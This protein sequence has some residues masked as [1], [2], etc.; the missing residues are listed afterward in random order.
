[1]KKI[2][3]QEFKVIMIKSFLNFKNLTIGDINI[4]DIK[5]EADNIYIKIS[6]EE[7]KPKNKNIK[8]KYFGIL[9][10]ANVELEKSDS[11]LKIIKIQDIQNEFSKEEFFVD[12][13]YI[14]LNNLEAKN[15]IY[16]FINKVSLNYFIIK[17]NKI[18]INEVF[19]E[20]KMSLNI[21]DIGNIVVVNQLLRIDEKYIEIKS[22]F[23]CSTE[24]QNKIFET[25][26]FSKQN[27]N[28]H[29]INFDF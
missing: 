22:S 25:F 19:S 18:N 13:L 9:Y 7:G 8:F 24:I 4:N 29:D 21:R 26:Y 17:F 16:G 1:M 27:T 14:S 10:S 23:E 6:I 28:I 3:E 20:E 12:N 15:P 5:K 2:N 11:Y